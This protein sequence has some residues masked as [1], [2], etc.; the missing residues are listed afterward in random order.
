LGVK[1]DSVDIVGQRVKGLPLVALLV[2]ACRIGFD[3]LDNGLAGLSRDGAPGCVDE[4][5]DGFE[6]AACGGPDC[7]DSPASCG[8]G[9]YPA[10]SELCDGYDNDCDPSTVDGSEDI[11]VG[12]PCD[13]LDTDFCREGTNECVASALV[14]NDAT[15]TIT[16]LC[17]NAVDDNCNGQ[18]DEGCGTSCSPDTNPSCVQM[19]LGTVRGD[20]GADQ[21]LTSGSDEAWYLVT[22]SE[23]SW[24]SIA[25]KAEILLTNGNGSDFDLYVYC[26]QCG[27]VLLASSTSAGP[28]QTEKVQLGKRDDGGVTDSFDVIVEIRYKTNSACGG[29]T[30]QVLGNSGGGGGKGC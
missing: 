20:N 9:C 24:S 2:G 7:D 27:G 22:I 14:C 25:L 11:A 26:S 29:W 19:S 23:Q 16:E 3:P 1:F 5:G 4:D 8:A 12:E 30:L 18:T 10:A 15:S 6:S 21:L 17:A 13:G 28:N